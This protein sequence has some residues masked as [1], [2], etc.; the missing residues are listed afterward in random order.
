[1]KPFDLSTDASDY[2]LGAVL[3]QEGKLIAFYSHKLTGAKKNYS[4][5]EK[6]MLSI[7]ETLCEFHSML[8]G[9]PVNIHTN[10]LNLSY[11][12]MQF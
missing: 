4:V 12:T 5:G 1:M 2:Q 7:V 10:H 3:M 8:L 6:E 9:Y 11:N